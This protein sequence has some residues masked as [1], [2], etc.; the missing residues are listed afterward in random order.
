MASL[1]LPFWLLMLTV[2]LLARSSHWLEHSLRRREER[3]RLRA[4]L[5][6]EINTLRMIYRLNATQD[7][8][9]GHWLSGRP[10]FLMFR[11]SLGKSLL[12]TEAEVS[13]LARAHAASEALD[14]AAALHAKRHRQAGGAVALNLER[15]LRAARLR[16][17][18]AQAVLTAAAEADARPAWPI[19]AWARLRR[20]W[21]PD[22]EPAAPPPG[23]EILRLPPPPERRPAAGA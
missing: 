13:A 8:E 22:A 19:R 23:A 17:R 20:V 16:A 18:I 3:S 15:L 9:A 6:G 1:S 14:A 21:V 4:G 11:G 12:L 10:Y 5:I 2:L 7:M